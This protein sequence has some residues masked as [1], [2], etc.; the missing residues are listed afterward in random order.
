[1]GRY[2]LTIGQRAEFGVLLA[3][4]L[5][6]VAHQLGVETL[7]TLL[8]R[9]V[10]V[11]RRRE[12]HLDGAV[13]LTVPVGA[14]VVA[15]VLYRIY[16]VVAQHHVS[17]DGL[18]AHLADSVA[19]NHLRALAAALDG[20]S[21]GEFATHHDGIAHRAAA[22]RLVGSHEE[23]APVDAQVVAFAGEDILVDG[24]ALDIVEARVVVALDGAFLSRRVARPVGRSLEVDLHVMLGAV[25]G[26]RL[27]RYVVHGTRYQLGILQKQGRGKG[28]AQIDSAAGEIVNGARGLHVHRELLGRG[29]H[30]HCVVAALVESHIDQRAARAVVAVRCEDDLAVGGRGGQLGRYLDPTILFPLVRRRDDL[31]A[32]EV[33]L[34]RVVVRIL[35]EKGA[36]AELGGIDLHGAAHPDVLREPRRVDVGLLGGAERRLAAFPS[37]VVEIGGLPLAARSVEGVGARPRLLIGDGREG[38]HGADLLA[39]EA[40]EFAVD[41]EGSHQGK[42]ASRPVFHLTVVEAVG[43]R[44]CAGVGVDGD[45]R[46]GGSAKLVLHLLGCRGARKEHCRRGRRE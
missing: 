44:P 33:E 22:R 35:Y 36:V 34:E 2:G 8:E 5:G 21:V 46:V 28:Q 29:V 42:V 23:V 20:A 15:E 16:V 38:L 10:V 9:A 4:R 18:G 31:S 39:H 11:G 30:H 17:F 32:V 7:A 19:Q 13:A 24:A 25:V 37:L 26:L 43:G 40:I 45:E 6:G 27:V 41:A 3:S 14:D 1:M 12:L